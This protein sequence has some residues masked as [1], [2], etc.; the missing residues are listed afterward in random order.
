MQCPVNSA[1]KNFVSSVAE[2]AKALSLKVAWC[3]NGAKLFS[4]S[5]FLLWHRFQS[6]IHLSSNYIKA[7][8]RAFHYSLVTDQKLVTIRARPIYRSA[9]TY[10]PI[11]GPS[12]YI[13]SAV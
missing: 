2:T 4:Q 7:L 6:I 12:R 13:V 11:S 8:N 5:K 9:D 10:R 3:K 1:P